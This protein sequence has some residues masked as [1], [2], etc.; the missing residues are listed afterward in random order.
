MSAVTFQAGPSTA[1]RF[2]Q[3]DRFLLM[4]CSR[5]TGI[6]LPAVDSDK[7]EIASGRCLKEVGGG[8]K[9]VLP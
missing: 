2:A 3:D 6:A 9:G 4:S 5:N 7:A 8:G 1:L